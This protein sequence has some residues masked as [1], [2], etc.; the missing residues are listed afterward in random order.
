MSVK[1][2]TQRETGKMEKPFPKLM[3]VEENGLTVLFN[4][5]SHGTVICSGSTT[6]KIGYYLNIWNM[7]IF[8]DYNHA[9]TLQND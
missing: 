3:K 4:T 6:Y 7:D 1:V 5:E 9:I 8:T 2:T